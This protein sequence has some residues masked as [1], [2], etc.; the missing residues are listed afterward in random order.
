MNKVENQHDKHIKILHLDIY[1]E[2]F[3]HECDIF[4]ENNDIKHEKTITLFPNIMV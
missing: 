1:R 4:Y 2:Y 3:N